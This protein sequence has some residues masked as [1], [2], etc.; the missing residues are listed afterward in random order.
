MLECRG[1]PHER[2]RPE[3]PYTRTHTLRLT[4]HAHIT[5][6]VS[7]IVWLVSVRCWGPR[8]PHIQT[9]RRSTARLDKHGGEQGDGGGFTKKTA[10]SGG[11]LRRPKECPSAF[12]RKA[13]WLGASF[14]LRRFAPRAYQERLLGGRSLPAA[15]LF[16]CGS[17]FA[18][19]GSYLSRGA[20]PRPA[21]LGVTRQPRR[22]IQVWKQPYETHLVL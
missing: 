21:A 10:G 16:G 3:V 4:L 20:S 13:R 18:R 9:H 22:Q 5:H 7:H 19:L 8:P 11:G 17:G 6:D 12:S 14:W 1:R 15:P 2:E